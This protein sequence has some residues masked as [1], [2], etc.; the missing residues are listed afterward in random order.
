ML[1]RRKA[2]H[3]QTWWVSILLILLP[4]THK[5][6]P[7]HE[8]QRSFSALSALS[9]F[10]RIRLCCNGTNMPSC[11]SIHSLW[12]EKQRGTEDSVQTTVD[13]KRSSKISAALHT[14]PCNEQKTHA[15]TKTRWW[16]IH[17]DRR[18]KMM[19][20]M[21]ANTTIEARWNK[22]NTHAILHMF[23]GVQHLNT[24]AAA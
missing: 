24:N 21:I 8:A 7:Q 9:E 16:C 23:R 10:D 17:D 11:C 4:T 13:Y 6:H 5:T 2:T 20:P 18:Y 1:R 3:M 19:H 12:K 14:Q 22:L 15:H